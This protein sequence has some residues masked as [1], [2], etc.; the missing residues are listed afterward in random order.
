[1]T[2]AGDALL[3]W[4]YALLAIFAMLSGDNGTAILAFVGAC[5]T[6][7]QRYRTARSRG[8]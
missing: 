5:G 6:F 1:M 7:Y 4:I 3:F 2:D 8:L